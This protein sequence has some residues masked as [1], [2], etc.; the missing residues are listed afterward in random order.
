MEAA[1]RIG[2]RISFGNSSV[3]RFANPKNHQYES[4]AHLERFAL[5]FEVF[6]MKSRPL[7]KWGSWRGTRQITPFLGKTK[8]QKSNRAGLTGLQSRQSI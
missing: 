8:S 3:Q 7:R 5:S 2:Q 4:K 6:G 1:I